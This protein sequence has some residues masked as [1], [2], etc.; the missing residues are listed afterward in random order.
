MT[1]LLAQWAS[2]R[3]L[4]CSIL[5]CRCGHAG[6]RRFAKSRRRRGYRY[7]QTCFTCL[8]TLKHWFTLVEPIV[9]VEGGYLYDSTIPMWWIL[10]A[11]PPWRTIPCWRHLDRRASRAG[12]HDGET[13]VVLN[14]HA[15]PPHARSIPPMCK[16]RI[17]RGSV[18]QPQ[19]LRPGIAGEYPADLRRC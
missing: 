4:R 19:L 10:N 2:R 13:Q 11:R 18:I 17:M 9:P 15:V 5:I 1:S 6:E 3:L 14:L 16:P 7:A 8:A 12:R